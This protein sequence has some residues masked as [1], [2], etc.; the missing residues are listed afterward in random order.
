MQALYAFG[1]LIL[2]AFI[3]SKLIFKRKNLFSP[4]NYLFIYGFI[5]IFLGIF[6]G[7]SG[8]KVLN[9]QVLKDLNPLICL[10]LGWIGFLF[11]F[12]LEYKYLRRFPKKYS[13]LSI[14]QA[15]FSF[16]ITSSV[17]F[18]I[19]KFFFPYQVSF[20]VYG[21]SVSLGLLMTVN[22]PTLLNAISTQIPERGDYYYLGRFLV[23]VSGFW[24][25]LG[26]A[27]LFSVWHYP[28]FES[29]R[30]IKGLILFFLSTLFSVLLGYLFYL[31]TR[32]K[33][34]SQNL[35]V[36][37]LGMVFF[38]SG[39]AFY[40]NFSPLY[41]C[42]VMGIIYSNLTKIQER[43]YP[44]L[45]SAEKPLYMVFLVLIGA[46]WEFSFSWELIILTV[47]LILI[48]GLAYVLPLPL[49]Q[50]ALRFPLTLPLRYGF[51]FLSWGG[52]GIALAVNIKL[53][54]P[55]LL[56]DFFLS[57]ALLAVIITEVLSPWGVKFSLFSLDSEEK[58]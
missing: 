30:I 53:S 41:V 4:L 13:G 33:T 20:L 32:K 36:Y 51:C 54:Y 17:V 58:P 19:L 38:A 52:I 31:L 23:S 25:I 47:V 7:K 40:F 49:F 35:L 46:L 28:F 10:G 50:K 3:G 37:L 34:S 57:V 43:V 55:L 18:F 14:L 42:M 16:L 56:T 6:L 24:G 26:L 11:G 44:L 5:Y 29:K 27:L 1:I 9:S 48:R 45:F 21:L 39:S 8:L 2:L 22:S 15:L 12:Q